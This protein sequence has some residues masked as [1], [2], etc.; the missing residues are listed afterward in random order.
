MY[1]ATITD[2]QDGRDLETGETKTLNKV[3]R[4]V[5]WNNDK[6]EPIEFADNNFVEANI[7]F[8]N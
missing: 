2:N 6:D 8:F 4:I 7:N 5:L 1:E 3:N